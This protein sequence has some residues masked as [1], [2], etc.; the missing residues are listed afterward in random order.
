MNVSQ[1]DHYSEGG[2]MRKLLVVLSMTFLLGVAHAESL[3]PQVFEC[4]DSKSFEVNSQCMANKISSN[5][6]FQQAQQ[7]I[8]LAAED[9]T[10]NALATVSF[11][12]DL[13]LIEVVAHR[14]AAYAKLTRLTD[15]RSVD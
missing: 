9:N 14:D 3:K 13:Q 10:N 15:T 11:Y 6:T 1:E 8:V 7:E 2:I 12:P 4:M 5:V